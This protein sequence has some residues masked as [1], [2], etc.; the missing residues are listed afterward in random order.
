MADDNKFIEP[1]DFSRAKASAGKPL[2]ILNPVIVGVAFVFLLLTLAA[3][4]MFSA[5]AVRFDFTPGVENLEISG[6]PPT[7]QLGERYLMLQGSYEITAQLEGYRTLSTTVEV[8]GEPEQDLAF[9]MIKLPGIIEVTTTYDDEAI[10]GADVYIDQERVGTT[11]LIVDNVEAGL[12]DLYVHHARFLPYQTEIKV[13]GRRQQQTESVSL[14][15]AWAMVEISS[16]PSGASILVDQQELARTPATVE[17][18]QGDRT[19]LLKHPGYKSWESRLNI[20]AGENQTIE[21]IILAKSDGKLTVSS[22]PDLVNI[23]ISGQYYGQTPLSIALAPASNYELIATRAG[24]Q[25]LTR[26]LAVAPEEDQ[27]LRLTLKPVVGLIKLSVSPDGGELFV[28]NRPFGDPNQTLELTARNHKIK[29]E[30]PGY[31]TYK[32]E[33]IPQPGFSQQLNIIMQTEEAAKVS[34]IPQRLTTA[35]GDTIRFILPGAL[36]MGAGR[37]EPGR[38]S[39]EVEKEIELTRA[40]Y[41]GEREVS[42]KLFSEFDPGHDSGV[43]GRALLSEEDRPVVNI[44]W[45]QAVRY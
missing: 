34:A 27:S 22:S 2:L 29:V 17:V 10:E 5:R 8:S 14:K 21:E 43:L 35:Q 24:Y 30:L 37:R 40:F 32:T 39:N 25:N 3:L 31:A 12:R 38:R 28:D 36:K 26:K 44:S 42:N 4:F 9:T 6:G 33:V 45:D 13:E 7:Y 20:I 15:P 11:P 1:A 41:L 19:I 23:T 18:L 16:H